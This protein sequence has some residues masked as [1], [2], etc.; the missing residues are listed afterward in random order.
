MLLG[1][2]NNIDMSDDFISAVVK[3]AQFKNKN[4]KPNGRIIKR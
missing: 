4:L 2:K 3:E 1:C